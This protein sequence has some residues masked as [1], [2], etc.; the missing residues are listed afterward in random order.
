[1]FKV[2]ILEDGVAL[3]FDAG[4]ARSQ[5]EDDHSFDV[6]DGEILED[7]DGSNFAGARSQ[8]EGEHTLFDV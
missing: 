2:E 5:G 7:V 1:M 6:Q 4:G 3:G 8:G